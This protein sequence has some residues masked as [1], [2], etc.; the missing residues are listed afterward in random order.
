MAI[1][2]ETRLLSFNGAQ[3]ESSKI[4]ENGEEHVFSSL[5]DKLIPSHLQVDF[6]KMDVEGAE[7]DVLAGSE[8]LWRDVDQHLLFLFTIIGMIYGIFPKR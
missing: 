4:C 3:G 1:S 6:I 8:N 2:N 5:L 7:L